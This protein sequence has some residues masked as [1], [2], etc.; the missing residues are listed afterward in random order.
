[1]TRLTMERV[2]NVLAAVHPTLYIDDRLCRWFTPPMPM[3][4]TFN[5]EHLS[6]GM[7]FLS[8]AIIISHAI[9]ILY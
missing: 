4:Y 5:L 9:F 6:T 7:Q 3:A 2:L 8:H 1:M